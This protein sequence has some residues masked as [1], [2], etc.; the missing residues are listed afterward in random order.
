MKVAYSKFLNFFLFYQVIIYLAAPTCIIRG[1]FLPKGEGG[2]DLL[3]IFHPIYF[4]MSSIYPPSPALSCILNRCHYLPFKIYCL[5][6]ACIK[7]ISHI[8][9][10]TARQVF[11]F[12][13]ITKFRAVNFWTSHGHCWPLMVGLRPVLFLTFKRCLD[14][15]QE[16][17]SVALVV[18]P[19]S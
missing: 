8:R 4:I 9:H 7:A 17:F 11:R 1:N 18:T 16:S 2:G 14:S 10:F 15:N 19:I 3:L 12:L 13:M 5:V 6:L